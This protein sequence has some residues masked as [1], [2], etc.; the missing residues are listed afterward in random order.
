LAGLGYAAAMK[1][2]SS[3]AVYLGMGA[4]LAWGLLLM[5]AGNPWLLIAGVVAYLLALWRIGCTAGNESH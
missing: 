4:V 2:L 1:M 3:M 5:T